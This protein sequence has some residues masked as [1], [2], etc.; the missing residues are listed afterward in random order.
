M[1]PRM[2][3][4]LE[5]KSWLKSR[6]FEYLGGANILDC[7]TYY[8]AKFDQGNPLLAIVDGWWGD[9]RPH[10]K[11]TSEEELEAIRQRIAEEGR[12]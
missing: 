7:Y 6:G 8:F 3:S 10:I 1:I 11:S 12:R 4:F 5:A 9:W 2:T